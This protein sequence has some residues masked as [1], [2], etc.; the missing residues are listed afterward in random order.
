MSSRTEEDE[1]FSP[2]ISKYLCMDRINLNSNIMIMGDIPIS[3]TAKYPLRGFDTISKTK[4]AIFGS[5]NLAMEVVATPSLKLPKILY[6]TGTISRPNYSKTKT[7]KVAEV[8]HTNSA[9]IVELENESKFHIRQLIW[10]EETQSFCDL[11][12]EVF[13]DKTD[14]VNVEALIMGDLHQRFLCPEVEKSYYY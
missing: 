7:G 9:L 5:P 4:S 10:S 3:P 1:K 12:K 2:V 8:H 13:I 14:K 6:T 11:N